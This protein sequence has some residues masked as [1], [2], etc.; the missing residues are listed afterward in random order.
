MSGIVY[1][2]CTITSV[3][4]AILLARVAWRGGGASIVLER[5]SPSPELGR[6]PERNAVDEFN[7][8]LKGT[9]PVT[10]VCWGWFC[11]RARLSGSGRPW[12][13]RQFTRLDR[14]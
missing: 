7:D 5:F 3:A 4:S 8:F 14:I 9:K 2:L 1:I 6:P 10:V 12:L 13:F 11:L